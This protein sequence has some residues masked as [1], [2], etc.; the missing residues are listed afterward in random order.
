MSGMDVE[1]HEVVLPPALVVVLGRL[2]DE[3]LALHDEPPGTSDP[4]WDRLYPVTSSATA[5]DAE[6]RELVHPDLVTSR[7]EALTAIAGHLETSVE[8]ADGAVILLDDDQAVQFLGAVNDVRLALAARVQPALFSDPDVE[9]PPDA[10]SRRRAAM[11]ELVDH[12]AWL[13]EQLLASLDAETQAHYQAL[14]HDTAQEP[15]PRADGD[16]GDGHG[17]GHDGEDER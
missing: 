3:L 10:P 17:H 9:W 16:Q 2:I 7:R 11:V 13:Q 8:S 15:D 4:V 12:L 14:D 5:D 1:V 6:I